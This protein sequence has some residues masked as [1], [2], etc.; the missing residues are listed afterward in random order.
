MPEQQLSATDDL[1]RRIGGGDRQAMDQLLSAHRDRLRAMVGQRMDRRLASRVAASDIVQE[2]LLEAARRLPEYVERQRMR[3][4][5]WL[6]QIARQRLIDLFRRH[7]PRESQFGGEVA[8]SPPIT[9]E[10]R[11]QLADRFVARDASPSQEAIK[12]EE[13]A[14]LNEALAKLPPADRELLVLRYVEKRPAREL[15]SELGVTDGDFA[16][17]GTAGPSNGSNCCSPGSER[18]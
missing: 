1:L 9:D 8:A 4:Y 17:P 13:Q 5:L 16:A 15:A 11:A 18:N 14:R 3:F 10:S 2:A 12:N 6:R 7:F